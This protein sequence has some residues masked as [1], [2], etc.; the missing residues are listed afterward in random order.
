[1]CGER[2]K[3]RNL[4]RARALPGYERQWHEDE[5]FTPRSRSHARDTLRFLPLDRATNWRRL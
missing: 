2:L 4:S 1:M 5:N 3:V